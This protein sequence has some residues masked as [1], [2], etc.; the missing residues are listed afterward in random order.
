MKSNYGIIKK[1]LYCDSEFTTRP[2]FNLYCSQPC[3]NPNN[4][5]GHTPWNKGIKLTKEQKAKQNTSGLEKGRGWNKGIPNELARQY[6]LGERNPNWNG[7][8]NNLRPKNPQTDL[9]KIYRS[10]VRYETYRTIREMKRNGDHVPTLG[11]LPSD[12]QL[13]HIIP[14]M[15]GFKLGIDPVLLGKRNNIQFI[16]GEENRKKWHYDQ[17]AEVVK[18]IIGETN[19]LFTPGT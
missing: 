6:M 10:K 8:T 12:M 18:N 14:I 9:L 15:Q 17:P 1:C 3:K 7:K 5:P 16:T 19:G 2:R 4:R 11:K 13:D